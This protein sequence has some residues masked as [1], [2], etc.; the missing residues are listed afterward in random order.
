MFV[1]SCDITLPIGLS[2][3]DLWSTGWSSLMVL[4]SLVVGLVVRLE[5]LVLSVGL[6]GPKGCFSGLVMIDF[7]RWLILWVHF[8]TWS[9]HSSSYWRSGLSLRLDRT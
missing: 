7:S 8:V 6:S 9:I 5:G 4:G 1:V 2:S 3:W